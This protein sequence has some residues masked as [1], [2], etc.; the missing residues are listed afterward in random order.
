MGRPPPTL[1]LHQVDRQLLQVLDAL[2]RQAVDPEG[3]RALVAPDVLQQDVLEDRRAGLV[4]GSQARVVCADTRVGWSTAK[5]SE[6][7]RDGWW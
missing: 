7:C 6:L 1:L 5:L 4:C 3:G 2:L